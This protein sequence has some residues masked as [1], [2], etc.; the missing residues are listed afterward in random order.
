MH[1]LLGHMWP[2]C[3]MTQLEALCQGSFPYQTRMFNFC[4][5]RSLLSFAFWCMLSGKDYI[6]FE[7]HFMFL[8]EMFSFHLNYWLNNWNC[9]F[10]LL[11]KQILVLTWRKGS[12]CFYKVRRW[13]LSEKTWWWSDLYKKPPVDMHMSE[14]MHILI[15]TYIHTWAYLCLCVYVLIYIYMYQNNSTNLQYYNYT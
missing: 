2:L 4:G 13:R 11:M 15:H 14:N 10:Q 7:D 5:S 1:V 12:L 9:S 3:C 8:N 6:R